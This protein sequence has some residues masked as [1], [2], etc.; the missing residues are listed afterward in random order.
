[1]LVA[2]LPISTS[3]RAHGIVL[4]PA[5]ARRDMRAFAARICERFAIRALA[6]SDASH[7][8]TH[9]RACSRQR[10]VARSFFAAV[11]GRRRR[12]R[13]RRRARVH[14]SGFLPIRERRTR[15][16]SR[17]YTSPAAR[18]PL[19]LTRARVSFQ[20]AICAK[21]LSFARACCRR[22][23]FEARAASIAVEFAA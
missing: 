5:S 7:L 9:A 18:R 16:P 4:A 1:M 14:T 6:D 2:A 12:Q 8:A 13:R 19:R 10:L 17:T 20:V 23:R 11:D 21:R 3:R 22:R 15:G